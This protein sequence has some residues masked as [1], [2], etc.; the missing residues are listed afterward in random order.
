MRTMESPKTKLDEEYCWAL[1]SGGSFGRI[2]LN[3][4]ATPVIVPVRYTVG[5]RTLRVRPAETAGL[6]DA[7]L[8]GVVAFQADGLDDDTHRAWSVHAVGRVIGHDVSRFEV[9][10]TVIEGRWLTFF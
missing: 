5:H 3:V 1:L 9:H 6:D 7:V 8:T 4:D 2:A 10:P